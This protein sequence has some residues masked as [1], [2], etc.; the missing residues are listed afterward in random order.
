MKPLLSTLGLLVL[1]AGC[2]CRVESTLATDQDESAEPATVLP[3]GP[4]SDQPQ[5]PKPS[6]ED[7][8]DEPG[9]SDPQPD[10][11]RIGRDEVPYHRNTGDSEVWPSYDLPLEFRIEVPEVPPKILGPFPELPEAG[12]D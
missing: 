5:P 11:A 9:E 4:S 8:A 2:G 6:L 10:D 12:E 3:Q 7:P 1:L